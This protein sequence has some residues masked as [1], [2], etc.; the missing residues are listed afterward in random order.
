M[1]VAFPRGAMHGLGMRFDETL[2][3]TEDWDYCRCA[4]A[5]GVQSVREITCVYRWWVHTGS[6]REV[7]SK[8]EWDVARLRVQRR[9]ERSSICR[10]SRARRSAW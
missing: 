9:F 8:T 6:S 5:L 4:A 10:S 2:D 3:T 7:H 1:S